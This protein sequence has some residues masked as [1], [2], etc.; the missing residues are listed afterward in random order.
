MKGGP[1][2]LRHSCNLPWQAHCG[3]LWGHSKWADHFPHWPWKCH[4]GVSCFPQQKAPL[5]LVLMSRSGL[6]SGVGWGWSAC[7]DGKW[8]PANICFSCNDHSTWL[9]T[10][11]PGKTSA[12]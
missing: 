3:K 8:G 9:C 6:K 4:L 10:L 1:D 7:Q 12:V 2:D 11:Q 5:R